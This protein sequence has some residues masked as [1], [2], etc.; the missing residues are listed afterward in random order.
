MAA[1]EDADEV[2]A[3]GGKVD[4]YDAESLSESEKSDSGDITGIIEA[5][6]LC[7]DNIGDGVA[8]R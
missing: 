7:L 3:N 8:E 6:G 5:D 2:F 4:A 1:E